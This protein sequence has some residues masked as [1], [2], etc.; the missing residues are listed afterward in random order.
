MDFSTIQKKMDAKEYKNV[1]EIYSDV[2]L[3]CKNAMEYN[4]EKSDIHNRAKNLLDIFTRKWVP[5]L[6]KITEEVRCYPA[7]KT[8]KCPL[9]VDGFLSSISLS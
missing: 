6:P 2:R 1:R 3:I 9:Q 5:F 7:F 4:E 8:K